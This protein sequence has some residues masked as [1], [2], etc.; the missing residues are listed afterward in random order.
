MVLVSLAFIEVFIE[1][2]ESPVSVYVTFSCKAVILNIASICYI[3]KINKT[4]SVIG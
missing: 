2:K 1:K 3:V 4:H